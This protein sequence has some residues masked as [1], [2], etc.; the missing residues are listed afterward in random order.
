MTTKTTPP[1][2]ATPARV[3]NLGDV[4]RASQRQQQN[5]KAMPEPVAPPTMDDVNNKLA[6]AVAM[7]ANMAILDT[8]W[9]L[10]RAFWPL[11]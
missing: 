4:L 6:Q 5:G 8:S 3:A 1:V 10:S 2:A 11:R 7:R 9:A